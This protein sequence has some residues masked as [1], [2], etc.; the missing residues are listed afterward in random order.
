MNHVA[1][2][3]PLEIAVL[4]VFASVLQACSLFGGGRGGSMISVGLRARSSM[5][6]YARSETVALSL[7]LENTGTGATGISDQL[8]G[9]ITIVSVQRDGVAVAPRRSPISFDEALSFVLSESIQSVAEGQSLSLSWNS[10]ADAVFGGQA[11]ATVRYDSSG[12]HEALLYPLTQ[13]GTYR[14]SVVYEYAAP[15]PRGGVP[16]FRGKT[17]EAVVTFTVLP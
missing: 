1:R 12:E 10:E 3:Q 13:P 6:T 15:D 9:N 17:A 2:F 14:L 7:Q 5:T 8:A 16:V 11:I 4:L